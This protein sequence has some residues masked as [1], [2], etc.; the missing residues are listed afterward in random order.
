M[1]HQ[2]RVLERE[3]ISWSLFPARLPPVPA[4]ASLGMAWCP[5]HKLGAHRVVSSPPAQLLVGALLSLH[6]D[7]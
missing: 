1:L 7:R 5:S 3:E 4:A 2:D 6:S